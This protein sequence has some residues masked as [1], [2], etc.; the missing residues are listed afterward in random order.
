MRCARTTCS[1]SAAEAIWCAVPIRRH[2]G[3]EEHE[4]DA[5]HPRQNLKSEIQDSRAF[6]NFSRADPSTCHSERSERTAGCRLGNDPGAAYAPMTIRCSTC[7]PRS[8]RSAQDDK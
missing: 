4:S 2:E 3:H 6:E 1:L 8:I 7:R 5:G